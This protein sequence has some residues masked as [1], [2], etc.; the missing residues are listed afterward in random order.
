MARRGR[1]R[2]FPASPGFVSCHHAWPA[3]RAPLQAQGIPFASALIAFTVSRPMRRA[4]L[5]SYSA[6]LMRAAPAPPPCSV[7]RIH[8][9][10]SSLVDV[11]SVAPED[12]DPTGRQSKTVR[13]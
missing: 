6:R 13:S 7:W 8:R 11:T 3:L 10:I 9:R 1:A 2:A 4:T 12:P 5:I